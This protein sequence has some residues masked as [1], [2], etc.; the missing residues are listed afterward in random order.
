MQKSVKQKRRLCWVL[1]KYN[2]D[3]NR[4]ESRERKNRKQRDVHSNAWWL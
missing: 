2:D 1:P 3:S 4:S